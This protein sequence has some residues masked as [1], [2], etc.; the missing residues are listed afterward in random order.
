MTGPTTTAPDRPRVAPLGGV[1]GDDAA[2]VHARGAASAHT[3]SRVRELRAGIGRLGA[4]AGIDRRIWVAFVASRLILLVAA[5]VAENLLPRNPALTSGDGAPILRSLTSWD[6]WYYLGIVRDGYHAEPVAGAY[7]DIAFLPLYPAIVRVLSWPWPAFAG[8]VSVLVSNATL[9]LALG[10]LRRLGEPLMGRRRASEAAAL[11]AIYP[12]AS[13][14]GMAYT[15]SLFLLLTVG[16]FLAAERDR[17]ALAGILFALACLTRLQGA[18]LILPLGLLM[19][20]RDGWRPRPSLAWLVLGPL[21]GLAFLG[22]VAAFQ[23]SGSAYLQAQQ[24][25]GREGFAGAGA[26]RTIGSGLTAYQA[27]LLVTLLWS[28]WLFVYRR[29]SGVRAEYLLIPALFIAAELSSGT[30]EAVGR[31]TMAAFPYAWLLASRRGAFR[32]GW[33]VVSAGLYA[34]VALLS[35]GGYWVP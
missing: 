18:V 29:G 15:E 32:R 19:L 9:L 11:L 2:S 33:P 28:V 7:R 4:A 21:A 1:A 23:G 24:A 25:W 3:A 12:F 6:G 22:W 13:A 5:F 26:G 30:L 31:V 27:T 34:T 17:R 20:R 14:F 16:A 10:L 35:F 8:L